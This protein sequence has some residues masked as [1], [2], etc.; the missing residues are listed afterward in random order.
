MLAAASAAV[1]SSSSA[2]ASPATPAATPVT[3]L[4]PS[5]L[6]APQSCPICLDPPS[7]LPI[8]FL[9]CS[10]A[11]HAQCVDIW[12]TEKS[13]MCPLCRSDCRPE[14]ERGENAAG[15]EEGQGGEQSGEGGV[16]VTV[17][18]DNTFVPAGETPTTPASSSSSGLLGRFFRRSGNTIAAN[19]A[20]PAAAAATG[21]GGAQSAESSLV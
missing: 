19:S 11:F 15:E 8:R 5:N 4:D 9:P 2:S 1:A 7:G 18:S 10:H 17:T 21:P 3:P 20:A 13:A 6:Q 14:G 16:T 12:L